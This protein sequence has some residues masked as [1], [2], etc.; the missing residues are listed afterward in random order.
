MDVSEAVGPISKRSKDN[1]TGLAPWIVENSWV[2]LDCEHHLHESSAAKFEPLSHV[3]TELDVFNLHLP[4]AVC[5]CLLL[6]T[7]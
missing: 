5:A 7:H 3:M 1:A 2:I 6:C 4:K